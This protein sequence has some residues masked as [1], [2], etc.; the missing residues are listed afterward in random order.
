MD[1][2]SFVGVAESS[3]WWMGIVVIASLSVESDMMGAGFQM[4][5]T[6]KK[7]ADATTAKE[8]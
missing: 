2:A 8:G 3:R 7:M 1:E 5:F 6:R 4:D